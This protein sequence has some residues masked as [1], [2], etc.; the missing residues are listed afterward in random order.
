MPETAT[1]DVEVRTVPHAMK[2][3]GPSALF[4]LKSLPVIRRNL[5]GFMTTLTQRYGDVV[6]IS[7]LN[8]EG[9]LLN[10]PDAVKHVL[11][12]H[13][14]QYSKQVFAL[15][16][17]K[18]LLG[19]GLLTNEGASWLRQRRLIQ[20]AFHR[21]RL[22]ALS[23]VMTDDT[24]AMLERW[25]GIAQRGEVL[26]VAQEMMRLTLRN[27]GLALLSRDLSN[28]MDRLGQSF[29]TY[30][31]LLM[32]YLYTPFPPL[33]VPTPRNRRLQD[34]IRELDTVIE[35]IISER[36]KQNNG[37]GD[38]LSML[39]QARD[40]EAMLFLRRVRFYCAPTQRTGTRHSGRI[41]ACST[42]NAFTLSMLLVVPIS[43]TFPL[44]A[45][46]ASASATS[47]P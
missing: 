27:V 15:K 9:Y 25:Q 46:H 43:P 17:L 3:P 22:S 16:F 30:R 39:L 28:E 23:T 47:S 35:G 32:Q 33:G 12:G 5:P 40:L 4:L 18:A 29:A 24:C 2:A 6:R 8:Q 26:D 36:R 20:P 19:E 13:H 38:L 31:T 44:V 37:T 11:Q 14:H 41:P 21:K 45:G 34:T 1:H 42:R 10:H 7:F